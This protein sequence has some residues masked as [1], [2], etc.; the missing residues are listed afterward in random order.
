MSDNQ[1]IKS[2]SI[3]R[4]IA[5]RTSFVNFM[6][7]A[8]AGMK[9]AEREFN[10]SNVG[11]EH[12]GEYSGKKFASLATRSSFSD[13]P[14]FDAD[15]HIKGFDALAWRYL[16]SES[17]MKSYMSS[18]DIRKWSL[19]IDGRQTPE[20]TVDNIRATFEELHANR[21]SMMEQGV[22]DVF[23]QLSYDYKTNTPVKFGK[24][25]I[26]NIEDY[27]AKQKVDDINRFMHVTDGKPQPDIR[28][29]F[30]C[31]SGLFKSDYFEVNTFANGNAH[32]KF[33]R[34]DLVLKMNEILTKHF[35]NALP[36][37]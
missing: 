26:V 15:E 35:P 30:E 11:G 33:K 22:L 36:A 17:G 37:K 25:I 14:P 29:G 24:K 16:M 10:L 7:A 6:R 20:L 13:R 23:N 12:D 34:P 1:I 19:S 21:G 4:L 28:D 3:E 27:R 18:S 31:K 5:H 9:M 8:E 2:T 32:L